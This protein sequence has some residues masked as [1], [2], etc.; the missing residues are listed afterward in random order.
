MK[1]RIKICIM[2]SIVMLVLQ[3]NKGGRNQA[4]TGAP[5]ET[6]A[7]AC[8]QC[9]GGGS[10]FNPNINITM[11]DEND[12]LVSKYKPGNIYNVEIKFSS[13]SGS[14]AN[15]GFQAVLVDKDN[16]QAGEILTLGEDV[17]KLTITSK[18]YLTQVKPRTDGSF[19]FQWKAPDADSIKIYSAGIATNNNGGTSGDK[20]V[21]LIS[22]IEKEL[23]SSS[24]ES[25]GN[26]AKYK[27]VNNHIFFENEKQNGE[28]F[29]L[30]GM[31]LQSIEHG[32][33]LHLFKNG[34]YIL[35][36]KDMYNKAFSTKF[37]F[38]Q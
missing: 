5:F 14:P 7:L 21:R 17:R 20:T 13:S 28:I 35:K 3:S 15:Y 18:T 19:K 1:Q 12:V 36:Y 33:K 11:K 8:A 4:T 25:I 29:D 16:N 6:S 31:K 23:A 32:E 37:H 30:N 9:H 10:S 27:I 2:I 38:F 22:N 34:I 26:D 24:H